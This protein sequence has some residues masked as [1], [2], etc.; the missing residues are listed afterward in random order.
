MTVDISF[1]Q[2]FNEPGLSY[3][4]FYTE[5]IQT[6]DIQHTAEHIY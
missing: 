5:Y 2:L 4:M 6:C 1:R 3:V